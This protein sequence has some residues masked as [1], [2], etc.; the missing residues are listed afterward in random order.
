[1][2]HRTLQIAGLMK[3]NKLSVTFVQGPI[4]SQIVSTNNESTPAIGLAYLSGYLREIG[5]NPDIRIISKDIKKK[6]R[7]DNYKLFQSNH[8][9]PYISQ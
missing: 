8:I 5:I 2:S 7:K 4:I 9:Y 1:M 6:C 3:Q